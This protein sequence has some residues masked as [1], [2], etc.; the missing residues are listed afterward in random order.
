MIRLRSSGM[1]R[2]AP[3]FTMAALVTLSCRSVLT[4]DGPGGGGASNADAVTNSVGAL[5][6]SASGTGLSTTASTSSA[7]SGG[8][9][10]CADAFIDVVTSDGPGAHLTSNCEDTFGLTGEKGPIGYYFS[11]GA[12]E[13]IGRFSIYGCQD[14][15]S[16]VPRFGIHGEGIDSSAPSSAN[17]GGIDYFDAAGQVWTSEAEPFDLTITLMSDKTGD[18]VEGSFSGVITSNAVSKAVSGTFRV[19]RHDIDAP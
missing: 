16:E 13:L 12:A 17:T 14:L 3:F 5:S 9:E 10:P 2:I 18:P 4:E 19:C 8:A 7:G 6:S 11:A 1:K 15:T